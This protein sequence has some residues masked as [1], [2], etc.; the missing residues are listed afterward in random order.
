MYDG[1]SEKVRQLIK[2][3]KQ[4]WPEYLMQWYVQQIKFKTKTTPAIEEILHNVNQPQKL[5]SGC[6]CA[7]VATRLRA[8]GYRGQLPQVKEHLFFI[9]REYDGPHKSCLNVCGKNRPTPTRWDLRRYWADMYHQL[10]GK[11]DNPNKDVANKKGKGEK[12]CS[13]QVWTQTLW[14]CTMNSLEERE[15]P[16][17]PTTRDAYK[18]R[19]LLDGLVIG[20]IDKNTGEASCCCPVLY[21]EALHN[22]YSAGTGYEEH[23][24]CKATTYKRKKY[25]QHLHNNITR[26][27]PFANREKG[28]MRDVVNAWK[29]LYKSRGWSKYAP[30]DTKGGFN[31][32]YILFKAKNVTDPEKR[33]RLWKKARPIAPGTKHPMRR[34]LGMAGRAWSFIA[35]RIPGEHMVL[36]KTS[37]VPAFIQQSVAELSSKGEIQTAVRDIEGCFPNM[38]K[39]AIRLALRDITHR[40]KEQLNVEGVWV[41][42]WKRSID[43][44][45][46]YQ[47]KEGSWVSFETL[48]DIMEFSLDHAYVKMPDGTLW[49]QKHGIPMGDPLSPGMTIGTCA[50]ME[51]E[52]LKTMTEKDKEHFR[53][54]RYMDDILMVLV[55]S[56]SWD[57]DRFMQDFETSHCYWPPLKLEDGTEDTFLE[58]RFVIENNQATYRL[59][60]DNETEYRIWRY[61]DFDSYGGY[62]EKRA[63]LFNCLRK[64]ASYASNDAQLLFSGAAKLKEFEHLHYPAGIRRFACTILARDTCNSTWLKLRK[65]Q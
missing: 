27:A 38:P 44:S 20:P 63:N 58:T 22:M 5:K 35:A 57:T 59:K 56:P 14:K 49:K 11:G 30:F 2:E 54:R 4:G 61:H 46:Q 52:W 50:W 9:G 45:W 28:T 21:Q 55:R 23:F 40:L 26:T 62:T 43:C 3:S 34:L 51:N 12:I 15:R 41:P 18:L 6:Q 39:N 24:P 42:K 8:A 53:A 25:G 29:V 60:N 33:A 1:R 17:W 31:Q 7:Q 13:K 47:G 64:V 16:K 65:H 36:N 48:L 37:Q 19:K 32:P 10:P